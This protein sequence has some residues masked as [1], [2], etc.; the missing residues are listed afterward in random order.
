MV[1]AILELFASKEKVAAILVHPIIEFIFMTLF[2]AF[3]LTVTIHFALFLKIN[4]VRKHIKET[5]RLDIEP[6]QSFKEQFDLRQKEEALNVETFVQEKFSS[7]QMF[8]IPVIA[9]MKL[10]QMMVSVFILLGVLGTFIGLTISL[11]GM[12]I[13]EDF[14]VENIVGVLSGID[15]AFYTSIA[16]MTFSLFTSILRR[17]LNTEYM[18]TDLMLMVESHFEGDEQHGMNRLIEVSEAIHQSLHE[19]V[20]SFVGFREYTTGLQQSAKDLVA[21][22][23]GLSSHLQD[24]QTLFQQ[25]K[26]VTKGFADGTTALNDNF[27]TLF[28]YFKKIDHRN[29]RMV[30]VVEQTYE[31]AEETSNAQIKALKHMENTAENLRDYVTSL[32]EEQK[33]IRSAY[34]RVASEQQQMMSVIEEHREELKKIFGHHVNEKLS[35]LSLNLKDLRQGFEKLGDGVSQ[36]P[37]YLKTMNQTQKESSHLLSER[38][39]QLAEFNTTFSQSLEKHANQA[40]TFERHMMMASNTFEQFGRKNE[41]LIQEINATVSQINQSFQHRER[42]MDKSVDILREALVKQ[43]TGLEQELE[44]RLHDVVRQFGDAMTRTSEGMKRELVDI[45]RMTEEIQRNYFVSIQ[46]LLQQIGHEFQ[47]YN[48]EL[49]LARESNVNRRLEMNSHEF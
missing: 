15:V 9:V 36:L 24:F 4:R 6:L 41:Q 37:S 21:F 25:M 31:K 48:K 3:I 20:K 45:R 35:H 33:E 10:I 40:V 22:N 23:D 42:D 27:S 2:I 39:R 13:S 38:M 49:Q 30:K 5:N 47:I 43:I 29:E 1:R 7:W 8:R 44:H 32:V 14:H 11:S 28:S 26:A 19:V 12:N 18:M 46:K 16:G 34:E 17:V